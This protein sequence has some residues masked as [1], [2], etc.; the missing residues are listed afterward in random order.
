MKPLAD[1]LPSVEFATIRL[2]SLETCVV[3]G[4]QGSSD[5]SIRTG[6]SDEPVLTQHEKENRLSVSCILEV[7]TEPDER[8]DA[9]LQFRAVFQLQYRIKDKALTL[10]DLTEFLQKNVLHNA[11]PYFRELLTSTATRMDCN[12]IYLPLFRLRDL[13]PA[14]K[15][16]PDAGPQSP[17][18]L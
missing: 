10:D 13:E 12:P 9:A 18:K 11:W 17:P 8:E 5:L 16:E 1:I 15:A 4:K 7:G 2:A 6:V 14:K 3:K